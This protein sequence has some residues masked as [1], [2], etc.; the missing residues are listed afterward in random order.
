VVT[1]GTE[2]LGIAAVQSRVADLLQVW[3]ETSTGDFGIDGHIELVRDGH[4]P[5]G[6]MVG[7]QV[8]SGPSYL[9]RETDQGYAYTVAEQHQ[10]YW[11]HYPVPVLLVLHDPKERVSYWT[12]VRQ[13][14]RSGATRSRTVV[15]PKANVL[16]T[17]TIDALF[18]NA[19]VN[20]TEYVSETD[21]LVRILVETQT[22]NAGFDLSYFDLF[23]LGMTNIARSLYFGM[24]LALKIAEHRLDEAQ[25]EHGMT[26]GGADYDFL[27][28]YIKF[29]VSQNI[30]HANYS[31][32]LID[33]HD[34]EMIPEFIVPLSKRGRALRDAISANEDALVAASSIEGSRYRA[35]QESFVE[36]VELPMLPRFGRVADIRKLIATNLT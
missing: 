15:V 6:L 11:E 14:L 27:E 32:L 2:R 17:A 36:I 33:L 4:I 16:Q 20:P 34:R 10:L 8:K 5:T 29:L 24:D 35:I 21:D 23:C 3:R 18:A 19:G 31:D 22:G 28:A 25:A 1:Y 30:V 9:G 26:V 7:V 12:D 13:A